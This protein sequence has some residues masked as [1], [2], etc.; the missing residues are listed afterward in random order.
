MP[1]ITVIARARANKGS[2]ALLQKAITEVTTPTHAEAGCLKYALQRSVEDP[3][4]F[5]IVEK[6]I[7]KEAHAMHMG[8]PHVQALFEKLPGLL[9]GPAEI[10]VFEPLPSGSLGKSTI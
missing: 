5:V 2:E 9:A 10:Q 6:W 8:T 1:T 3:Q 4:L 7:S